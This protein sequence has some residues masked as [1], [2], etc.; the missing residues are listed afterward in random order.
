LSDACS[1]QTQI[2]IYMQLGMTGSLS[3]NYHIIPTPKQY[4]CNVDYF[5]GEVFVLLKARLMID[6]ALLFWNAGGLFSY[7]SS[8]FGSKERRI[9]ILGLDGAGKTT[10]LYRLQVGEVVTTIPS[11]F[12]SLVLCVHMHLCMVL[13][14]RKIM[15]M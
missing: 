10:I 3:Y 13:F 5:I 6:V 12:C 9:L 4:I 7:F 8:L 15:A 2:E 14:S 1:R 11:E